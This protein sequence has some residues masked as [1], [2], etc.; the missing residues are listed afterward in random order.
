MTSDSWSVHMI[1]KQLAEELEAKF[2]EAMMGGPPRKQRQ[3]ALRLRG[4]S[5]ETVE[6]DDA[7]NIIEPLRCSCGAWAVLHRPNCPFAYGVT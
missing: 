2:M 6:L 5:F 7:G 3:T 1:R 4:R